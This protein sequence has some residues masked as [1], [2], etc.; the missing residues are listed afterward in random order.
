MQQRQEQWDISKQEIEEASAKRE[1]E[2]VY[3]L[4]LLYFI[5]LED[6]GKSGEAA[7]S[8]GEGDKFA[9]DFEKL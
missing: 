2:L 6:Y 5:E 8:L 9:K 7:G 3:E 1:R 4:A